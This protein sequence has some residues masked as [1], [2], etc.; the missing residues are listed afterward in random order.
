MK[1]LGGVLGTA[2]LPESIGRVWDQQYSCEVSRKRL[3]TNR[4][5][6][7]FQGRVLGPAA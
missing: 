3:G 7:Q 4:I 5:A 1:S 6:V 2:G